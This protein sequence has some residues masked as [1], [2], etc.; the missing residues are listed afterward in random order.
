[1]KSWPVLLAQL[2]SNLMTWTRNEL[3]RHVSSCH[4]FGS[5]RIVR[6]IFHIPG[7]APIDAK[8]RIPKITLKRDHVYAAK[9]LAGIAPA[10]SS[11]DLVL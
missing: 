9:F 8:D 7:K 6:D 2:A 4:G 10:L 5:L 3:A 11:D 1:L